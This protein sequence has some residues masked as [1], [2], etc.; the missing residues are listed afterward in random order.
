MD[1]PDVHDVFRFQL[2]RDPSTLF[3]ESGRGSRERGKPST[4]LL[5]VDL[6]S[7]FNLRWQI[8][9]SDGSEDDEFQGEGAEALA[10][11]GYNSA[12]TP[13]KK[14]HGN[15]PVEPLPIQRS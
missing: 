1:N 5:F 6:A 11:V 2:P 14:S 4:T 13:L 12:L 8:L 9:G 3:Q 10:L 7:Y 15:V